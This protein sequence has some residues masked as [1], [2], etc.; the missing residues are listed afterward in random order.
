MI[1][2]VIN[3]IKSLTLARIIRS[4]YCELL[5]ACCQLFIDI[6]TNGE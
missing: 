3:G 1:A 6:C 4:L 2:I 5:T